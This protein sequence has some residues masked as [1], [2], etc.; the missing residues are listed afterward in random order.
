MFRK[1]GR[2]PTSA[3]ACEGE[4]TSAMI[5]VTSGGGGDTHRVICGINVGHR[6][7]APS[8]STLTADDSLRATMVS[9]IETCGND[10]RRPTSAWRSDPASPKGISS[11]AT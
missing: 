2:E 9:I 10:K 4:Q 11:F 3:A 8:S 6:G 1:T 7:P 5:P